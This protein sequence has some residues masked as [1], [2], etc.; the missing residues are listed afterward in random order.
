MTMTFFSFIDVATERRRASA[1]DGCRPSV[2]RR[3]EDKSATENNGWK[4]LVFVLH[5]QSELSKHIEVKE[6]IIKGIKITLNL[7]TSVANVM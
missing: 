6:G 4:K 7:E 1:N 5:K 2:L 3:R